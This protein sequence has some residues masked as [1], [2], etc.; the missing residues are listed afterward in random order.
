MLDLSRA[1]LQES[2]Q[3]LDKIEMDI[4]ELEQL[5]ADLVSML[6]EQKKYEDLEVR[7]IKLQSYIDIWPW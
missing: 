3:G 6:S 7:L 4:T 5:L 1:I 2:L